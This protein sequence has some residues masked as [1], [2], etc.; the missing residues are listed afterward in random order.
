MSVSN[1]NTQM[2]VQA[3][4]ALAQVQRLSI[5]KSLVEAG[6]KGI[7]AGRVSEMI[8]STPSALSFHLKAMLEAGLV[9]YQQ[10]GRFL[11]YRADFSVINQLIC[12]LSENCCQGEA[13]KV[14]QFEICDLKE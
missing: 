9:T 2:A 3:M 11:V 10:Q 1:M 12:F 13:C 7:N 5:F 6:D 14:N 4:S 8:G